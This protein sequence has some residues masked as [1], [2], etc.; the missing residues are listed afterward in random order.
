DFDGA[1][2]DLPYLNSGKIVQQVTDDSCQA[3]IQLD[4]GTVQECTWAGYASRF[5]WGDPDSPLTGLGWFALSEAESNIIQNG[6][7]YLNGKLPQLNMQQDI[8]AHTQDAL[9]KYFQTG[10]NQL[11]NFGA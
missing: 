11:Q 1:V 5:A 4:K 6:L 9:T 2:D 10:V 8:A 3:E 7:N